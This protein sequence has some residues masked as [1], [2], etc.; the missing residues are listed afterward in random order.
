MSDKTKL[1]NRDAAQ[2]ANR[3][4]GARIRLFRMRG[5]IS[6]E[7]LAGRL[8][9]TFQQVQKY[10]RGKNRISAGG[11]LVVGES[12]GVSVHD[13][14]GDKADGASRYSD[15]MLRA[16][17]DP[18]VARVIIALSN[19]HPHKRSAITVAVLAMIKGVQ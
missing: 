6:Q 8:G 19:L 2:R 10:E 17:H 13:L 7:A 1:E 12:L 9:V 15:A 3:D 4:I 5:K 16:I 11:L 14:L 18:D